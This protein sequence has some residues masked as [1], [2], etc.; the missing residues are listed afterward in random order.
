[1][2]LSSAGVRTMRTFQGG[3]TRLPP[4]ALAAADFGG[5][6]WLFLGAYCFY[7]RGFVGRAVALA[8]A[9]RSAR[10]A[11]SQSRS[12]SIQDTEALQCLSWML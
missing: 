4:E 9:V 11:W 10:Q 12:S 6:R 3:A 2:I 1:M 5:A 8:R 7:G